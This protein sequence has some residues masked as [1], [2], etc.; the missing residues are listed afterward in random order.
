[1]KFHPSNFFQL[2][3]ATIV[4]FLSFSCN[5][6]SDLL[7]EYVVENPQSFLTND[8]VITLA[9]NPIIIK[10]LSNDKF[11]QPE[12]VVITAVTPPK[13]GTAEVQGDNTVVYTPNTDESGTDE[14][15]YTT[16]VTNP[17]SSV[18]TATGSISVTVT[19]TSKIPTDPNAVNISTYGAVGNGVTDDTAALQAAFDA[20]TNLFSDD[21]KTYL[22]SG[23]LSLKKNLVQ[24]I[25]FNGS[26]ITRN[27]LLHWMIDIDKRAYS[28]SLTTLKNLVIDGND[29][30]GSV[31]NIKS[32]VHFENV[33]IKD[34][35]YDNA[36]GIRFLVFDDP[37]MYGQSVFDNVNIHNLVS[38][39]N[40]GRSGDNPG[41]VH[42]FV[43]SAQE[44]PSQDTQIVY[45][46]SSLYEIWGED[47]GGI[48][49]F[50]PGRDISNSPL[51]FWFE[52]INIS[53]AQRRTVKN[54]IGNTTWVNCVFTAAAANNPNLVDV[55]DG[56]LAAAGL[57]VI[58]GGS[59]ALGATNNKVCGCTFQGHPSDPFN[60]WYTQVLVVADTGPAG[61][62]FSNCTF[63]GDHPSSSKY[64]GFTA[65]NS[66]STLE[67]ISFANCTFGT[68]NTV[69]VVG[70]L[71]GYFKMSTDNTYVDGKATVMSPTTQTYTQPSIT[72]E[73]CPTIFPTILD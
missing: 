36:N 71:T 5:K 45:V 58:A 48:S 39:N 40:N 62:D 6:D 22:I 31:V 17:D 16:T 56:G 63:T 67:S 34:V 73:A 59:S 55:E 9:N 29:K 2:A 32:R 37:G 41:A 44:T 54:F 60:S 1:M 65:Y 47:A 69:R 3:L 49:L 30:G 11:D 20:G 43:V 70:A 12:E 53:D 15:D 35:I 66:G 27:G 33:E 21:G 26:T 19:P 7:A 13:M 52:N 28:N 4:L 42:G 68:T 72:Y 57:F 51:S 24:T 64:N 61:A 8:E 18:S 46:N 50:S 38:V 23:T 25:D 10:P 14:F